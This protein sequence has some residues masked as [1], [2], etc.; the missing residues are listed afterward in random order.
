MRLQSNTQKDHFRTTP[1]RL[2][3]L[4]S[5]TLEK[6]WNCFLGENCLL[7]NDLFWCIYRRLNDLCHFRA[8]SSVG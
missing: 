2:K 4:L 6:R 7:T 1:E 3:A 5:L 8:F